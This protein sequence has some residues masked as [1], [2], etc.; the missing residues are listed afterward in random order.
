[1][2]LIFQRRPGRSHLWLGAAPHPVT[3]PEG[4]VLGL[5]L[6]GA[7]PSSC[8]V[9]AT[10]AGEARLPAPGPGW[11]ILRLPG[12]ALSLRAEGA[13]F[14]LSGGL[15]EGPEHLACRLWT[16]EGL[17]PE[18]IWRRAR[19]LGE[20]GVLALAGGP[21]RPFLRLNGGEM[22]RITLPET[23]LPGP[24]L[25]VLAALRG[26]LPL[27]GLEGLTLTLRAGAACEVLW[28]EVQLRPNSLANS[29]APSRR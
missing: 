3:L 1:M 16:E 29:L 7:A 5:H 10:A 20:G 6:P 25:P 4:A 18:A 8:L 28:E 17:I 9:V 14:R 19:L 24:I 21:A 22:G 13:P 12:R 27:A 26:P 23:P 2:P 15:G 11:A